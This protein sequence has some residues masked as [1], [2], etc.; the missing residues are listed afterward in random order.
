MMEESKLQEIRKKLSGSNK[1]KEGISELF[2]D[3]QYIQ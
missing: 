3:N 2:S 1:N